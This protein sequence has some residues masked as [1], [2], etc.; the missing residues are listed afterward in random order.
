MLPRERLTL[1][2]AACPVNKSDELHGELGQS[3][4]QIL[5]LRLMSEV[6]SIKSHS[7]V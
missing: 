2:D 4:R 3:A 6:E 5:V 1:V 7:F